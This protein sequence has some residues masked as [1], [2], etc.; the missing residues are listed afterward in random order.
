MPLTSSGN[1][2]TSTAANMRRSMRGRTASVESSTAIH[3]MMLAARLAI[4]AHPTPSFEKAQAPEDKG[5][6][7]LQ[8]YVEQFE[9]YETSGIPCCRKRENEMQH[10]TSN[11]TISAT[12]IM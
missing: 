3:V 6:G 8:D 10:E 7:Y 12:M 1:E 5:E 4:K 2:Y 9:G 11:I